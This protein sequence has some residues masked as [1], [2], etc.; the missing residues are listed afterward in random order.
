MTLAYGLHF[1]CLPDH[2]FT[3]SYNPPRFSTGGYIS[4]VSEI[5]LEL[6]NTGLGAWLSILSQATGMVKDSQ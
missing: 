4:Q 6:R 2:F 3:K 5:S 1:E